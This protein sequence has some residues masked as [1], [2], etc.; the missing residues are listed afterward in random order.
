MTSVIQPKSNF[1]QLD[2]I[3]TVLSRFF[4]YLNVEHYKNNGK[5]L[6][7]LGAAVPIALCLL[8][9]F[10][11]LSIIIK[12]DSKGPV[13]YRQKRVG[14]N[15]KLFD[16]Y[17]FRT[18]RD[19]SESLSATTSDND[20][21]ITR[22]GKF[23]RPISLDEMPQLINILKGD[24]SFIG[25]RPISDH[26]YQTIK[27]TNLFSEQ[28]LKDLVPKVRPGILGWAIFQGR[29]K[30]SYENRCKLNKEYE[31]KISLLFDSYISFLTLKK[32]WFSYLVVITLFT[33][34]SL[35]V[36]SQF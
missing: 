8:P 32:Y 20:Q 29:E 6:W 9:L 30:I 33:A 26:E 14:K 15:G 23:I 10:A 36:I 3:E 25:P 34:S 18:M 35:F 24:M 2:K 31:Q 17:K 21:R 13:F 19:G 28:F 27:S 4:N 1:Q 11:L 16:C 22:V 5:R 7:D 12:M